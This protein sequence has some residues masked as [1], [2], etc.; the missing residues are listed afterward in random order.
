MPGN[1]AV[2][3][4]G[5]WFIFLETGKKAPDDKTLIGKMQLGHI[6]NFK[7]LFGEK[8]LFAAGPMQDP[9]KIKRG[10][11]IV[12]APSKEVLVDYFQP[13]DYVREG[14][15]LLNARR[16]V[17]HNELATE[18]IDPDGVE[19]VRIIQIMRGAAPATDGELKA[20]HAFLQSL[21]DKGT[22]GA[23]YSLDSGPVTEIIFS[24]ITDSK[25]LEDVFADYPGTKSSAVSIAVWRQWLGKG[26]L[27]QA[28]K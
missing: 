27:K 22:I 18:G 13:D 12:R 5:F 21:I 20:N 19:E 7:R 24:R 11:V 17:V 25:V 15:M 4:N 26:V 28:A 14:Y 23:W 8:I 9:S 1:P 2:K 3:P 16:T 6:E 10:I